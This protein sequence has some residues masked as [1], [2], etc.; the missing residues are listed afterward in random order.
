VISSPLTTSRT[1]CP[2]ITAPTSSPRHVTIRLP[3]NV[4]LGCCI[5]VLN[6][7]AELPD[8]QQVVIVV[9]GAA[10]IEKPTIR[11]MMVKYHTIFGALAEFTYVSLLAAVFGIRMSELRVAIRSEL[12]WQWRVLRSLT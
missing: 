3:R 2:C 8:V 7:F 10:E 5:N 9:S 4:P 12:K 11:G 6:L 1:D